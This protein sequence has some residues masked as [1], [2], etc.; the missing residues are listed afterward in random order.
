MD[1]QDRTIRGIPSQDDDE[2]VRELLEK[3]G[4]RPTI[5]DDDLQAISAVAR[6]AWREKVRRSPRRS[7]FRPA[8]AMAA[9]LAIVT[10][11][12]LLWL[13]TR[14]ELLPSAPGA[15]VD[16][17]AGLVYLEEGSAPPRPI[18]KGESIPLGVMLFS[19]REPESKGR[20]SLRLPD[21]TVVRLD[22]GT[23]MRLAEPGVLELKQGALYADTGLRTGHRLEIRTAAGTAR[24]IGTQFVVRLGVTGATTLQVL[25]RKGSVAVERGGHTFVTA[26]GRELTIRADGTSSLQNVATHGSEWEWIMES[27]G[28]F[29]IEGRN[30]QEFLNWVGRETGWQIQYA[31][32]GLAASAK[33]II[34]HGGI[35][36]MRADRAPFLVLPSAGLDA[37]LKEGN[38]VINRSR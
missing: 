34:L 31:D 13:S 4:A 28:G 6:A 22:A 3:A 16:A 37:E 30:L 20:T 10:L 36:E 25:V 21:G 11:G 9:S 7:M 12:L 26:A 2:F 18:A 24:D 19:G 29:Q 27:T 15:V 32:D 14:S 5:P 35:G 33:G 38:L 8:F 1:K 17:V 23:R